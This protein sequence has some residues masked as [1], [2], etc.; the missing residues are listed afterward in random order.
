MKKVTLME[1]YLMQKGRCFYCYKPMSYEKGD[2]RVSFT[3]DHFYPKASGIVKNRNIVLC[4]AQCNQEKGH[5]A[6]TESEEIRF[7]ELYHKLDRWRKEL[8]YVRK[9]KSKKVIEALKADKKWMKDNLPSC[10]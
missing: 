3:K 2:L 1:L 10:W 8:K 7:A 6:P 4:H 5:R 9:R